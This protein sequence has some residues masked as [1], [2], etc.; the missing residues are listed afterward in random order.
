MFLRGKKPWVCDDADSEH[1]DHAD[2]RAYGE[3]RGSNNSRVRAEQCQI[4]MARRRPR[5]LDLPVPPTWGGRRLGAGRKPNAGPA[6]VWHVPRPVDDHRHPVLVTLRGDRRLRSLRAEGTFPN[7][8]RALA[9]SNRAN[10]RVIHFSVQTDH[11]H[12]VVEAD[13]GKAL[14]KGIQGLAGRC[15]RAINRASKRR[16]R[17]WSDRYHRRPLR[18][19]REM[20]AA[21]VYVLQNFRKHL[22]AP[23]VIDPRSSGPWFG[24]WARTSERSAEPTPVSQP[25]S[26]LAREGWLRAGGHIRFEEAPAAIKKAPAANVGARSVAS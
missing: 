26:W 6:G 18:T 4:K 3:C 11:I 19:P 15:A 5:Q 12:L 23:A 17:V 8:R 22:R 25:R 20:R 13:G 2:Q 16:G 14:T 24:G 9:L 10:F 1:D 7:L 21:I